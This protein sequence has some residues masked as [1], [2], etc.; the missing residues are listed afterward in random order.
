[1]SAREWDELIA[2]PS[3]LVLDVRINC[4]TAIGKSERAIDPVLNNFCDFPAFVEKNLNSK[5]HQRIAMSSTGGIRC[6]KVSAY[7]AQ[8][9]FRDVYQLKGGALR[10]FEETPKKRST[11]HGECNVF[12]HRVAVHHDLRSGSYVFQLPRVS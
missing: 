4:E 11:F 8:L 3:F 2:D 1:M 9:A 12:D 7:L 6:E 10:Y 5:R